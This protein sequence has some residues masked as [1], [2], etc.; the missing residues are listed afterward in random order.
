MIEIINSTLSLSTDGYAVT[1]DES[2]MDALTT[3]KGSVIGKPN[4][5]TDFYKLKHRG[6]NSSWII[7][8]KRCLKD[9]C[10]HDDRLAFK[11]AVVNQNEVDAGNL[12]FDVYIANYIVKG[13]V[14][15]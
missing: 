15:V 4:Y 9:A 10:Q 8:F 12:Y 1:A 11:K 13:V 6:F 14:N 3:P 2:F 7:D 5:G